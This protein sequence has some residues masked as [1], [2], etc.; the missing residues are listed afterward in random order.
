MNN[1]TVKNKRLKMSPNGIVTLSA[2]ARK[3]LG[4]KKGEAIFVNVS[5]DEKSILLRGGLKEG[6]KSYKIS[7]GGSLTLKGKEREILLQ[8]ETRH[9]WMDVTDD[10]QEVRLY[11]F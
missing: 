10:T 8:G 4:M 2:A 9:Y 6:E 1:L 5:N 7:A 11:P 3:G